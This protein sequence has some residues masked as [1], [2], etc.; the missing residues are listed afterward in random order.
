MPSPQSLLP[1]AKYISTR[2]Y[3]FSADL[4][5]YCHLRKRTPHTPL[6]PPVNLKSAGSAN[7]AQTG[8][9][10]KHGNLQLSGNTL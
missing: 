7:R 2:S 6:K 4:T 10:V 8:H 5:Q 9:C 3:S 1:S